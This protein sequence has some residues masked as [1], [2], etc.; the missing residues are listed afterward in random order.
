MTTRRPRVAVAAA[1]AAWNTGV[2]GALLV[3]GTAW[4]LAGARDPARRRRARQSLGALPPGPPAGRPVWVHAVSVGEVKAAR[5]LVAALAALRPPPPIVLSTTTTTGY[6]TARRTFPG[7]YVFHAPVDLGVVVR[8]V[9]RRL[10]PGLVL[11]LELEAWPALLKAVDESGVPLAVVN[12]RMTER[13]FRRYRRWVWWLPEW[14]RLA[15]VAAQDE[16]C[17]ARFTALGVPGSRV[18]VAGNLKH[19]LLAPAPAPA[20]AAVA[21]AL[22]LA[23]G[24]P[25]IVAGSTHAGEEELVADAWQAAGGGAAARL[26]L[27]PRHPGRV[28]DV[29][30]RLQR[31]GLPCALRSALPAVPSTSAVPATSVAP[32][33]RPADT[34]LVV[35]SVGELE[36]LFGLATI[37]FLGGSLVPVGGH[38]VLEPAV[39]GCPLLVGPHLESCRREADRLEA[40]GGLQVVADGAEL[41]RAIGALLADAA[42]LRRL[43]DRARAAAAGLCGAARAHVALLLERGLL[44]ASAAQG[45]PALDL[46]PG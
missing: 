23:D 1:H 28:P 12:G 8:R 11:L 13:S 3:G 36:A 34:V 5:P 2:L 14:D 35:D 16:A 15:L 20:V 32:A 42:A 31:R 45:S 25:V 10:Q 21:R 4:W 40:A 27:V 44:R 18:V 41:A 26:V 46:A 29:V 37:V 33:A 7:L 9:L 6:E 24:R 38:N 19:D 30:R 22:G 17:A 43:G 39:A